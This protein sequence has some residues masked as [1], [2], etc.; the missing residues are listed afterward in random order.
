M[1]RIDE[2]RT[3][4]NLNFESQIYEKIKQNN[5]KNKKSVSKQPKLQEKSKKK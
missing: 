5:V 3:K 4:F 2:Y 1:N